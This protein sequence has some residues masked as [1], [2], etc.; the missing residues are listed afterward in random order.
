[1]SALVHGRIYALECTASGKRYVGQ[2]T[3]TVAQR[4]SE[5]V[6]NKTRRGCALAAALRKYGAEN[7]VLVELEQCDSQT[8]LDAAEQRWIR[9][10]NTM[11]PHGYNLRPGGRGGA[12]S[13]VT[14]RKLSALATARALACPEWGRRIAEAKLAS[15]YRHSAATRALISAKSR[16]RAAHNRGST[17]SDSQREK[18]RAAWVRRKARVAMGATS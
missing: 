14:R 6:C 15:G 16:G 9:L 1:M 2:T 4:L 10:L 3:R 12:H 5:H 11:A 18:L 17:M 7:F 13:E 8:A